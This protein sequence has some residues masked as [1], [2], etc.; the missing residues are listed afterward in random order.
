MSDIK[1]KQE[2]Q[3]KKTHQIDIFKNEAKGI[4]Y[5][6]DSSQVMGAQVIMNFIKKKK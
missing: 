5:V 2:A 6:I 1:S 3:K 4:L